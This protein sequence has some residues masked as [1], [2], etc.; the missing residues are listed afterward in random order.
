MSFEFVLGRDGQ[1]EV[2]GKPAGDSRA[3]AFYR[4]GA[5]RLDGSRLRSE[6]VNEGQPVVL[7]AEGA[8]LILRFD[9]TLA[10][11]LRRKEPSPPP[12][13]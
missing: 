7:R 2:T 13:P 10:F 12:V 11:R 8:E 3:T 4:S 9:D 5:Y 6:A 1:L